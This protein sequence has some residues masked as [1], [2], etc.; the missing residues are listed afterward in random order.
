[1]IKIFT[2]KVHSKIPADLKK[3]ISSFEEEHV[4]RSYFSTIKFPQ[5]SFVIR[6]NIT[7]KGIYSMATNEEG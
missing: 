2:S 7:S 6:K 1:M 3:K 5:E 4:V